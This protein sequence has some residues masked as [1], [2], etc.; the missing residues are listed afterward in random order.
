MT[1]NIAHR[2]FSRKYPENT[3]LAF[4]KAVEAH[5][6]AIELDVQMSRDGELM[7]FHDEEL[8]RTTD[9]TGF[10]KD[11]SRSE[12]LTLD[13][14]KLFLTREEVTR[15]PTLEEYLTFISETNI[16]TVIELKNSVIYYPDM[17]EKIISMIRAFHLSERTI[18]SSFNRESIRKCHSLAPEIRTAL[19]TESW[20]YRAGALT[21]SL[22][23]SYYHPRHIFLTPWNLAEMRREGILV[24][25]WTVND[26]R[27]MK[28]LLKSHV[29]GIITND[30]EL[31]HG[32]I[33]KSTGNEMISDPQRTK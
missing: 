31:L 23:A 30:P 24:Q 15:I 27:R 12:L 18:L 4:R 28:R 6:D 22:G 26:G 33:Q 21:K 14:G 25:P 29:H 9:G 16:E 8:N 2:G 17:E 1:K 10:L 3:M 32:I 5:C 19:I 11:Y 20:I 13:A 7:I